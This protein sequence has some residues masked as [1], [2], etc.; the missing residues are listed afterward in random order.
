M[1]NMF[2]AVHYGVP[3][4]LIAVPKSTFDSLQNHL[5]ILVSSILVE[6]EKCFAHFDA[7]SAMTRVDASVMK[8]KMLAS[9][10]SSMTT[11]SSC[12][13]RDMNICDSTD[14]EYDFGNNEE[15][16]DECDE[17]DC[18]NDEDDCNY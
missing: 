1:V 11:V 2:R 9:V 5:T 3:V 14:H 8:M 10:F 15:D 18:E 17:D 16:W 13:D 6:S 7:I 4:K 12:F